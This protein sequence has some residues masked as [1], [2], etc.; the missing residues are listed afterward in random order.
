MEAG[1]FLGIYSGELIT[2][3]IGESRRY[4]FPERYRA[5][6]LTMSGTRLYNEYGRTYLFR[7]AREQL[8]G[9]CLPHRKCAWFYPLHVHR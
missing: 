4:V 5:P 6:L 7:P 2:E 8:R 3:A 1:T 9:G